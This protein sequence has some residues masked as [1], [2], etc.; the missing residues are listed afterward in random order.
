[1]ARFVWDNLPPRVNVRTV[2]DMPRQVSERDDR[3]I[4]IATIAEMALPGNLAAQVLI[5]QVA[6]VAKLIEAPF[7]TYKHVLEHPETRAAIVRGIRRKQIETWRA[8]TVDRISLSRQDWLEKWW[9]PA[10]QQGE[11]RR[12]SRAPM[13]RKHSRVMVRH[14]RFPATIAATI[15]CLDEEPEREETEGAAYVRV[16]V[17]FARHVRELAG[18]TAGREGVIPRRSIRLA[19]S[20]P[21]LDDQEGNNALKGVGW[22]HGG[23]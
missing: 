19:E 6:D 4:R 8:A 18:R 9:L 15:F 7:E 16:P 12:L 3:A 22:W 5:H 23:E 14:D 1:M 20:I 10:C 21:V 17:N 2:Q 11:L 13:E